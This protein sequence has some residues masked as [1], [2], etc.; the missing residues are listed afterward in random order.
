MRRWLLVC[1][2]AARMVHGLGLSFQE[3]ASFSVTTISSAAFFVVKSKQYHSLVINY[4]WWDRSRPACRPRGAM[5]RRVSR[6]ALTMATKP[7]ARAYGRHSSTPAWR[8]FH[9]M[10]WRMGSPDIGGW[11]KAWQIQSLGRSQV[12]DFFRVDMNYGDAAAKAQ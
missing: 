5:P 10:R 6:R 3:V 7:C 1:R 8:A 4:I 11:R 2:W 12:I 9:I